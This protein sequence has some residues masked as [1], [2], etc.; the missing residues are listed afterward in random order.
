MSLVVRPPKREKPT[1]MLFTPPPPSPG[2]VFGLSPHLPHPINTCNGFP[3]TFRCPIVSAYKTKTRRS[4]STAASEEMTRSKNPERQQNARKRSRNLWYTWIYII[5]CE[6]LFKN[7]PPQRHDD[8]QRVYIASIFNE[9]PHLDGIVV[10][11]RSPI[12][13]VVRKR[14]PIKYLI[15]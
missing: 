3:Y 5:L 10:W 13:G 11:T 8:D 14:E 4:S 9:S 2:N 6:K 15:L 12:R 7:P 1:Y